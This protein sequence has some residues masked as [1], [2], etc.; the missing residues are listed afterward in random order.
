[1]HKILIITLPPEWGG[2]VYTQTIGLCRYLQNAG[3][4]EVRAAHHQ[5]GSSFELRPRL[6]ER[7]IDGV[8]FT[9]ISSALSTIEF[10][11]YCYNGHWG[12]LFR[13]ADSV[14]VIGGGIAHGFPA[15]R[16]K[17]PYAL[18]V[19]TTREADGAERYRRSGLLKQRWLDFQY[20]FIRRLEQE[21]L[22]KAGRIFVAS[23]YT[24]ELLNDKY[25]AE[26]DT[27]DCLAIPVDPFVFRPNPDVKKQSNTICYVGRVQDPR[28]GL[29]LLLAAIR[30]V[31]WGGTQVYLRVA[32]GQPGLRLQNLVERWQLDSHV[33]FLGQV[34]QE[35][36]PAVYQSSLFSVLPSQEEG[37]GIAMLEAMSCGLPVI[38]TR[39]GGPESVIQDGRNGFLVRNGDE[40]HLA[41]RIN[42]LINRPEIID[43]MGQRARDDVL[44]NYTPE[45][46]YSRIVDFH[47][48]VIM[49]QPTSR[50]R[51]PLHSA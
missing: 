50:L 18:W 3:R 10:N 22:S 45:R 26:V 8:P 46:A 9:C 39:C 40:E 12:E 47:T 15:T 42:F 36:L 44:M 28:K 5:S 19:A 1:M 29:S 13:W 33:T 27:K 20:Y 11:R 6:H 30:Q 7:S 51:T 37:L 48:N 34:P 38:A 17:L 35:D 43:E 21:T 4:F 31:L 14:Q 24:Q 49:N 16:S 41:E 32:G 23:R 2:G 25:A